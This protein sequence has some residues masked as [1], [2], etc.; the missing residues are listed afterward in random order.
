MYNNQRGVK[1]TKHNCK[2]KTRIEVQSDAYDKDENY[3][4]EIDNQLIKLFKD[5]KPEI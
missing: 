2:V 4:R 3:S 1:T 5:I